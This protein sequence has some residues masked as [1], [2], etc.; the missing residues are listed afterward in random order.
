LSHTITLG[1]YTFES[2]GLQSMLIGITVD[3]ENAAKPASCDETQ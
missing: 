2:L 1:A 3:P